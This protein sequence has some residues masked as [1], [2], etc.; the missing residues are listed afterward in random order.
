MWDDEIN[1]FMSQ[2]PEEDR[3]SI[4][5]L[6][7]LKGLRGIFSDGIQ[8]QLYQ[9]P[10]SPRPSVPYNYGSEGRSIPNK[11]KS[12]ST[13]SP[14]TGPEPSP[15]PENTAVG[16]VNNGQHQQPQVTTSSHRNKVIDRALRMQRA[17]R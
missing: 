8:P 6:A 7:T 10:Y 2:V 1:Y 4:L 17:S 15:I 16:H 9:P 11:T 3:S 5:K 14:D 13:H 12:P